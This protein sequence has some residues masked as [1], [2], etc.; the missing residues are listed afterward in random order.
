MAAPAPSRSPSP[1][2]AP[3]VASA[4][5]PRAAALLKLYS[6]A[7]AHTIKTCSYNN[8]ASCFPTPAK[9]AEG[10]MKI[11][12]AEFT[13]SLHERCKEQFDV[14]LRTRNVVASLNDLDRLVDEARKRRAQAQALAEAGQTSAHP[15]APHTL[16][17]TALY[18]AHLGPSLIQEKTSLN[19]TMSKLQ[20]ENADLLDHV[21]RQRREIETLVSTLE[22]VMA[23]VDAS[24][25]VL[26]TD[27]MTA[28][29]DEA[30]S[31][32]EQLS[33]IG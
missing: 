31:L 30:V 5:G 22:S 28:W 9:H 8:F 1:V 17:A 11:L 26:S 16:P 15:V 10:P 14:T 27:D 21:L 4:P 7:I 13:Q 25:A 29:T 18:Q 19:A 33:N 32:H 6:E 2:V 24:N 23:D 20:S 3:P 12:H